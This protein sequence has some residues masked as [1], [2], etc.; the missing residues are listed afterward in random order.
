MSQ[1]KVSTDLPPI[2]S[3]IERRKVLP[4]N[5]TIDS[6]FVVVEHKDFGMTAGGSRGSYSGTT[7]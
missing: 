7:K 4:D 3:L 5:T 1:A 2:Q 6:T